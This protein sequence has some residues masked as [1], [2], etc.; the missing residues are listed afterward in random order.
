MDILSRGAANA[1]A[2]RCS[3]LSMLCA[4]LRLVISN[5]SNMASN[6]GGPS[7]S[8]VWSC[9]ICGGRSGAG[10]G[11]LRVLRF[12]L[13][14]FIPPIAPQSPSSI[15]LSSGAC[16][17]GQ[18]WPQYLVDLVPPHQEKWVQHEQPPQMVFPECKVSGETQCNSPLARCSHCGSHSPPK[19]PK[20]GDLSFMLYK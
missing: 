8:P 20:L 9:G 17:I 4:Q 13:P 15:H 2:N 3:L 14:I 19:Q 11:F 12:P 6:R 7:S 5:G 18:K 16:T 10:A 1:T